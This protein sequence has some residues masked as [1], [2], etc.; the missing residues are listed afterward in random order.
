MIRLPTLALQPNMNLPTQLAPSFRRRVQCFIQEVG[1]KPSGC[2][3]NQKRLGMAMF[4]QTFARTIRN[5]VREPHMK[6]WGFETER[7]RKFIRTSQQTFPW[8]FITILLC[9]RVETLPLR[10]VVSKRKFRNMTPNLDENGF[11][12]FQHAETWDL[13]NWALL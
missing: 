10:N 12:G 7:A 3:V 9:P 2:N 1:N 6:M 11:L 5:N 13:L 4:K 8:N